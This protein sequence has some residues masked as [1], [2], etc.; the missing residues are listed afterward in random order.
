[1]T[2]PTDLFP[3]ERP[4]DR[5]PHPAQLDPDELQRSC[6]L[7][8]GRTTGP[9]GQHRNKVQTAV[10]LTHTPT[11]LA[12]HADER[13]S[14]EQNRSEALRRLRLELAVHHR[15]PMPAGD[16]RSPLWR[17]RTRN[18]KIICATDH[19]DFPAMLAEALDMLDAC[20][21][22]VKTAAT[23]LVV[24]PTQLVRLLADHPP[25][26]VEVNRLRA[27]RNLHPRR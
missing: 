7:T 3:W 1:M 6:T 8:R 10:T 18:H 24:T 2:P 27:A 22:D 25:A 11:G 19:A 9:G 13:R 15:C 21:L 20:S 4:V 12:G 14:P 17:A 23:R 26:L 16:A 5:T